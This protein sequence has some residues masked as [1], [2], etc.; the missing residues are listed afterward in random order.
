MSTRRSASASASS[1]ASAWTTVRGN[2]S[3]I[4]PSTA[5]VAS[6]RSRNTRTIV[7]SGTSWP[8]LMYRSA[9]R[10]SAVP[11]ATAA[12]R[13]LPEARTGIPRRSARIG[14]WVP[15]PA[16]GAPS[17]KRTVTRSRSSDEAFVVAHH[18]LRLDLLHRLH[19]HRDDDQQARA[20]EPE[21]AKIGETE[22]D[23]RWRDRHDREEQGARKGDPRDDPGEVVL[24]RAT[25]PGPREGTGG[26]WPGVGRPGGTPERT[27]PFFRSCS[28]VSSGLNVNAV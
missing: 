15:L 14:A 9:S 27:P 23:D 21:S 1:S 24:C 2:P 20:T 6:R 11:F 4:A 12:R 3:R 19:H 28:A 25:G 22:R 7:A 10:P 8:R 13:R 18:Q 17:R 5:S 26:G 16:P